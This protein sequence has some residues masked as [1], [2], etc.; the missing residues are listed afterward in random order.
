MMRLAGIRFE[1][2]NLNGASLVRSV[3]SDRVD[4]QLARRRGLSINVFRG[5][6]YAEIGHV[7]DLL[8]DLVNDDRSFAFEVIVRPRANLVPPAI[9]QPPPDRL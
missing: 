1:L 7:V 2:N 3:S 5:Y 4:L 9:P 6:S 8:N